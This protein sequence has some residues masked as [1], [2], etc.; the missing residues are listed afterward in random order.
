M[1]I[2]IN[3]LFHEI[4][5][6][7]LHTELLVPYPGGESKDTSDTSLCKNIQFQGRD[8]NTRFNTDSLCAIAMFQS[9]GLSKT[10]LLLVILD[11]KLQVILNIYKNATEA[12]NKKVLCHTENGDIVDSC[13]SHHTHNPIANYVN[14]TYEIY[15]Q[16]SEHLSYDL[17]PKHH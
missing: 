14:S 13:L 9:Q 11:V 7:S 5:I 1:D 4:F 10:Q 8:S 6:A 17:A 15:S 16:Q 12:Q 3:S 2:Q